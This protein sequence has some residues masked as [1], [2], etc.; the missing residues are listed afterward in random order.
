MAELKT[1]IDAALKGFLSLP[2][3]QALNSSFSNS[4]AVSLDISKSKV[5]LTE[6]DVSI[7]ELQ[8]AIDDLLSVNGITADEATSDSNCSSDQFQG[9]RFYDGTAFGYI[10]VYEDKV[11]LLAD[12]ALEFPLDGTMMHTYRVVVQGSDISLYVDG[13]LAIDGTGKFNQ[14]TASKQIEF[15]DIA[16]RNQKISSEWNSFRYTVSG[17]FAPNNTSDMSLEEVMSFP[18]S[19]V[20]RLRSYSDCLYASVDPLDSEKSSSIYRYKEGFSTEHRPVLAITKSNISAVVL[21]PNK[22]G[23]NIFNSSGKFLATDNG[24]QYLLGGKPFPFDFVTSFSESLDGNGWRLDG[25]CRDSCSTLASGVLSIDTTGESSARFHKYVQDDATDSWVK[26]ADGSSGWTVEAKVKILDDGYGGAIDASSSFLAGNENIKECGKDSAYF[27]EEVPEEDNLHAPGIYLN[28]GIHQEIVQFF[29]NGVRLKYARLFGT[30]DLTDQFY[31]IRVIGKGKAIAVYAKGESEQ[32]FKRLI[33]SPDAFSVRASIPGSQ[34]QPQ[35]FADKTGTLHAVWQE[36]SGDS[37]GIMYSRLNQKRIAVGSGILGSKKLDPASNIFNTRVALG[38]SP[39]ANIDYSKIASNMLVAPSASFLRKEVKAGNV[40]QMLPDGSSSAKTYVIRRVVDEILIE[41]DTVDDLS[42]TDPVD[43]LV[44]SEDASW[45]PL[46]RISTSVF[47]SSNPRVLYHSN[48]FAYVAFDSNDTGM[49]QIY[50]RKGTITPEGTTWG[51]TLQVTNSTHPAKT[52]DISE[53]DGGNMV[54]V[55][56]DSNNDATGSQIFQAVLDQDLTGVSFAGTITAAALHARKPRVSTNNDGVLVAYEDDVNTQGIFEIFAIHGRYSPLGISILATTKVSDAEGTSGNVSLAGAGH[57]VWDEKGDDGKTEIIYGY[58]DDYDHGTWTVQ[59]LTSS[60]GN[61]RRPVIS[62]DLSVIFESDRTRTDFYEL[63][64]AKIGELADPDG[65]AVNEQQGFINGVPTEAGV[66]TYEIS[67]YNTAGADKQTLIITILDSGLYASEPRTVASDANL[68]IITSSLSVTG[69]VGQYFS[70][71]ILAQNS[72]TSYGFKRRTII[73]SGTTGLD[74]KLKSYLTQNAFPAVASRPDGTLAI[75]WEGQEDGDKQTIYA[76]I[77]DGHTVNSDRSVLSYFPLNETTGTTV[78]NR[79]VSYSAEGETADPATAESN[80]T[81]F[82]AA[83]AY[84]VEAPISVSMFNPADDFAFDLGRTAGDGH[85]GGFSIDT[86]SHIRKSGAIDMFVTPHWASSSVEEHVF[87]GNGPLDST[88]PNTMVCGVGPD[89]L[90][91]VMRFRIVDSAG[92]PHETMIE[93]SPIDLWDAEETFHLR[94]VWDANNIGTASILSMSF[95]ST[96]IGYAVGARGAIFKTADSGITWSKQNSGTTYDLYSVDFIDANTGWACG[97]LGTVLVTTNAGSN[98]T[99]ISTDRTEDLRS[100]FFRTSSIGYACGADGTLLRSTNGG[101]LWTYIPALA[102]YNF[103]SIG[104]LGDGTTILAVGDRGQAFI[105]TDDGLTYELTNAI[106]GS[107]TWNAVSRTHQAGPFTSYIVGEAGAI[108]RSADNGATWDDLS[109]ERGPDIFCVSH[110]AASTTV[111]IPWGNDQIAYSTD[112]GTSLTFFDTDLNGRYRA[113]DANFNGTV[114]VGRAVFSGIGG[115]LAI[116]PDFGAVQ[117]LTTAQCGNIAILING[118]EPVQRRIADGPFSWNP[119]GKTLFFG[120]M[121]QGGSRSIDAI[122]DEVVIYGTPTPGHSVFNRHEFRAFQMTSVPLV[123]QNNGKRIEWGVISPFVK[124]ETQ[125]REFKMFYCEAREPISQFAW[126]TT[127]GLVD[128]VVF[129]LA[130]DNRGKLWAATANGIS[131]FDINAMAANMNAF[132]NGQAQPSDP[133]ELFEN[134][135]NLGSNLVSGEIKTIAVDQNDDIWAGGPFGLMMLERPETGILDLDDAATKTIEELTGQKQ[136]FARLQGM[137]SDNIT[138]IRAFGEHVYIG[139]DKGLGVIK[140]EK[141]MPPVVQAEKEPEAKPDAKT[142]A[143]DLLT[144]AVELIV[145]SGKTDETATSGEET[146]DAT[147]PE[148]EN[149]SSETSD[150]VAAFYTVRDGLPSNLIQTLAEDS[151]GKI[152]IGTDKGM[153]LFRGTDSVVFNTSNGLISRNVTSIT[154]DKNNVLYVGTGFGLTRIEGVKTRSFPPSSGIGAGAINGGAVDLDGK[155][156]FATATGLVEYN[157]ECDQFIQYGIQDGI[158][159]DDRI[160]DYQR[161]RILGGKLATKSCDKALV[162]VSVNGRE[163]TEGFEVDPFVPWIV[164]DEP[165]SSADVVDICAYPSWRKVHDFNASSKNNASDQAAVATARTTYKLYRK[166]YAAG[167]V[168]LGGAFFQG[169]E[170]ASIMQYSVFATPLPGMDGPVISGV[171]NPS[172]AEL[173]SSVSVG[174]NI[175]SDIDDEITSLPRELLDAQHIALPSDGEEDISS[176]YVEFTLGEDA[177]VYVVYDSRATALPGWLRG[178]ERVRVL[179]RVTDLEV[180]TDGTNHEKL[181]MATSGTNGCVYDILND[182][183]ICDISDEIA[184]DAL[185]PVGCAKITKEYSSTSFG[186]SLEATDEVTGVVDMQIS[187]R[188]D[189]TLDGTTDVP[190]VPFQSNYVF[191]LPSGASASTGEVSELPADEQAGGTTTPLPATIINNVFHEHL[192]EYLIGTKNPGRVYRFNPKTNEITLVFSTGEDEVNSMCTFGSDLIIGTGIN[193]KAFRWNGTTLSQLSTS[194]GERVLS[195]F[196]FANKVYLGYSP[197]GQIYTLDEFGVMQLFKDTA[198]TAVTSFAAFGSK[199]YWTTSNEAVVEGDQLVTTTKKG[200]KHYITVPAGTTSLSGLDG[201]TTAADGHTHQVID[202]VVQAAAGHTHGLNGSRSGKIFRYDPASGQPI[203]AHSDSDFAMTAIATSGTD[204]KSGVMFAGS[205]P[206]GKILRYIPEEDV[207]IKSFQTTKLTVNR[208]RYFDKMYALVDDDV[209]GFT[210]THWEFIASVTGTVHDILPDPTAASGNILVLRDQTI[211]ATSAAPG[212]LNPDICAYVRFRDAVGNLSDIRDENGD[213]LKCYNPCTDDDEDESTDDD[214]TDD[215]T[216]GPNGPTKKKGKNR[217][218]E[219][220]DDARVLFA[221]DGTQPFLSG[222]KIEEEV[223]AYYSEIFNGTNAFVQ[224]VNLA[225]TATTPA[226]TSITIAVRSA[227]TSSG[228]SSATWGPEFTSTTTND[229]TNVLGQFMQFR[230]TLKASEKGVASPVLHNVDITLRTSQAVHYFTTNFTLPD[231]LR[232]G[233]LTYNGCINPPTTDIIFGVSGLDSTDF[234]DYHVISPDKVFELPT[235]H[236]TKNM[237][238]GI[239]LIS[240]PAE[241]PIVDE[242]AL[243]VALAND[244]KARLNLTGMPGTT[245]GQLAVVTGQ[246]TVTTDKVQNHV[247]SL[248]F[249]A[250]ILDESNV[251]GETSINAGHKHTVIN[252]VIQQAAGHTHSFEIE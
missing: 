137:P 57:A 180:Y 221:L 40:L 145:K 141:R 203:I 154:I 148:A 182:P 205:S 25:N 175:Y 81:G 215:G 55:W 44:V 241:I 6:I 194:V 35:A 118:K 72:P 86:D 134:Y 76:S 167:D 21:D 189:F 174:D 46:I 83:D 209:Y 24:I 223:A 217:L 166:R 200:H 144:K 119:A 250:T 106:R 239:K 146:P 112:S 173:L 123:S 178:F 156:W 7:V 247:H 139:T 99:V 227:N 62:S 158:I 150:I 75:V 220:D 224:W 125:W 10:R 63:F 240:S 202:G 33:F 117:T 42:N 206:H 16:G 121:E 142:Q 193:G 70:Y 14:P 8:E 183:D 52:P 48:G 45:S 159:G 143:G 91:N 116:T 192:G 115:T 22:S 93:G 12:E 249:D 130:L 195:A 79:I 87:F 98:W 198:E 162:K 196:V 236:Q 5:A 243:L 11:E 184:V 31:T 53:T 190:F 27:S 246:R 110:A 151:N 245:D 237:R 181:F 102:A 50:V 89:G 244:A 17:A 103:N 65:L 155:L 199:L 252:G 28:D 197:G 9:I 165:L 32:V 77:Y 176:S 3:I 233:I 208:L 140:R 225:W 120:D 56:Q 160:R 122:M 168:S 101:L 147:T 218:M 230:A 185:G 66:F 238:I 19:A 226:N 29:A 54:I 113:I 90:N 100:I 232:R 149:T 107:Q 38:L 96:S 58:V 213:I 26:N 47:D 216:D 92:T 71:R 169:A 49:D 105:S 186:L 222:G 228:I 20:G 188:S 68:P 59:R 132:L 39:V 88:I 108:M 231:E 82:H 153:A 251:N 124:S 131:S 30:Q 80:G 164:F 1:S 64:V 4:G 204:G 172:G 128:D 135:T 136:I 74:V 2:E 161:Y 73:S 109:V 43:W 37:I 60:R 129:D 61:S 85:R 234:S 179:Y 201:T 229:I 211:D 248:T 235:E 163:I 36:V 126:D 78:K 94:A 133:R 171:E 114:S 191:D 177:I 84:S 95:P 104:I 41:L 242:F 219:V 207:F 138:V 187:P 69:I 157:V 97:E 67:T 152:W 34:E 51:T 23:G 210:G 111:W 18:Q 15:G 170:N 127:C 212:V 214:E 13:Q